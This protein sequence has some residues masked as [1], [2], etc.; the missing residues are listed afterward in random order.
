VSG[1][2]ESNQ[3]INEIAHSSEQQS[4]RI[5]EIN[6]GI[7]QVV[8]VIQQNSATAEESAAASEEM[9]GQAITLENM[10]ARFKLKGR[11]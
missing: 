6:T 2:S 3:I 8:Q 1:I 11:R 4:A 9:S 5:V 7:D 10:I